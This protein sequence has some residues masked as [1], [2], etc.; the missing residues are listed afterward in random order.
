MLVNS[1]LSTLLTYQ[2]P[3]FRLPCWVIKNIDRV[4]KDLL[5]CGPDLRSGCLLVSWR[6]LC[7]S[8]E[9]RGWGI[10]NVSVFNQV[11]LE[12]WWWKLATVRDWGRAMVV[13]FNYRIY[14]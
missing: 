6:N 2:M 3:I 7:R 13:Q 10:L 11:L 12:K 1:V 14:D 9:K 4:R 5:W 8:R